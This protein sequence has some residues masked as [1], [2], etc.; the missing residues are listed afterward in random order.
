MLSPPFG[1]CR[2]GAF[3]FEVE[4]GNQCGDSRA[5]RAR[6]VIFP[7]NSTDWTIGSFGDLAAGCFVRWPEAKSAAAANCRGD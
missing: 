1:T 5:L 2:A 3:L 7:R 4:D 6:V